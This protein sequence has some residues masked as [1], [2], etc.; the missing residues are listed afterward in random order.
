MVT[1]NV[2]VTSVVNLDYLYSERYQQPINNMYKQNYT[3]LTNLV[4]DSK[5]K[6]KFIYCPKN[7]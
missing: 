7:Q 2:L 1:F 4:S 3:L 6:L 5:V